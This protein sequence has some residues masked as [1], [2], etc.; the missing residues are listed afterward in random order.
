MLSG[1]TLVPGVPV[2]QD[3]QGVQAAPMITVK[4]R[5]WWRVPQVRS[6][7]AAGAPAATGSAFKAH[8]LLTLFLIR[9]QKFCF[10]L[11]LVVG[12]AI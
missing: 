1:G 2:P 9:V 7:P 10:W 12:E 11:K 4:P 5:G 3:D 6:G 8:T